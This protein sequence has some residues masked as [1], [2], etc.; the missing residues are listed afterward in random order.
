MSQA[1]SVS[2]RCRR[3]FARWPDRVAGCARIL[4]NSRQN[5]RANGRKI[6]E[7]TGSRIPSANLEGTSPVT[8]RL[9]RLRSKAGWCVG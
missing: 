8:V 9:M 1:E 5:E 2:S 7:V 6:A 4:Q 3:R